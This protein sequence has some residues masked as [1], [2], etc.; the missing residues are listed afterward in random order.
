M[1]YLLLKRRSRVADENLFVQDVSS[2]GGDEPD[3]PLQFA[4]ETSDLTHSEATDALRDPEVED[5]VPSIPLT[6]IAPVEGTGTAAADPTNA[7][8]ISAVG[9]DTSSLDGAGVTIAILDTGIERGHEAFAGIKFAD[10]DLMDFSIDTKGKS[11]SAQDMHGHG[12]HVAG[13]ILGRDV[14]GTRIGVARGVT[15]VLI[16]KV[17]GANGGPTEAIVNAINWALTRRAD[18]IS[19]SLGM[20]FLK[21]WRGLKD[22]GLP[23]D[24]AVS[25]AL[26]A[27]RS[28]VRLFDRIASEVQ[29]RVEMGRGA[30]LVAASGNESRRG[31]NPVFTAAVAPPAAADGFIPVGAVSR[32]PI[33]VAPFSNTL[34]QVCAPGVDIVSAKLGGGLIPMSGTSMATPHAA[35]VL[36]LWTQE[37]FPGGER[38]AKW[39]ADVQRKLE[40]T[41]KDVPGSRSDVGL[42]MV[43]CPKV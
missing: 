39:A 11:G 16:A 4:I 28:N 37:L 34:C 8:G 19:M 29:A 5:V 21:I 43:Q 17:L 26:E 41:V 38:P 18:I 32:E 1:N 36:A 40:T 3:A 35:G 12:T 13:T 31:Q 20:D 2:M 30:L 7:W 24:I 6:L 23:E 42:G 15:R 14:N 27:Y 22:S 33:S 25:R 10:D 9:A